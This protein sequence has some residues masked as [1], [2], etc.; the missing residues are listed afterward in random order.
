MELYKDLYELYMAF[1]GKGIEAWLKAW[2]KGVLEGW[3]VWMLGV[4][5]LR[6]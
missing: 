5:M 6:D 3:F 4:G 1:G 2:L